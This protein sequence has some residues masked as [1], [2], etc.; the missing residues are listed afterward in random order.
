[1]QKSSCFWD[2]DFK[3]FWDG[4]WRGL[5][6]PTTSNFAFFFEKRSI[7]NASR[8]Q[9]EEHVG[10]KL[11]KSC[12]QRLWV[13]GPKT[14]ETT[15]LAKVPAGGVGGILP[16]TKKQHA[17][18]LNTPLGQRPGEFLGIWLLELMFIDF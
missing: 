13:P 8:N 3:S 12:F 15:F 4:F 14:E 16:T 6:R 11:A 9:V 1:M 2:I 18:Y 10:K 5:G 17:H 7:K